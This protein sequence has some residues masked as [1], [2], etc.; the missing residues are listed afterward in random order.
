MFA[1]NQKTI[2][3]PITSS[4]ISG[5]GHQA[6][7]RAL[8]I[9]RVV[10]FTGSGVNYSFGQP[11]WG[12]LGLRATKL[13]F[14]LENS[15]L[16]SDHWKLP[17]E[18]PTP[19]QREFK[20]HVTNLVREIKRL[21]QKEKNNT[22]H[23][24]SLVETYF[25][26][27]EELIEIFR[28]PQVD[29]CSSFEKV[30]KSGDAFTGNVIVTFWDE[31][32]KA[33]PAQH[34]DSVMSM[35]GEGIAASD[36]I[37][38]PPVSKKEFR[39]VFAKRFSS[40]GSDGNLRWG[41]GTG[42]HLKENLDE[43]FSAAKFDPVKTKYNALLAPVLQQF[44]D[45]ENLDASRA[46]HTKLKINRFMTLNYDLELEQMLFEEAR[47]VPVPHREKFENFL[48]IDQADS[49]SEVE[50]GHAIELTSGSGRLIRSTSS[51]SDSLADLFSFGAFPTN[52]NTSVHHLHGRID[53]PANMIIIPQDYQRIYY[54][55]GDQPRSFDEA[56]HAVFTGS[57]ILFAGVGHSE[58]DVLKPL[59][60]FL[61][62]ETDRHDQHGNVYYLTAT[63]FN[64]ITIK[65]DH[66]FSDIIENAMA[67]NQDTT[68]DLFQTYGIYVLHTDFEWGDIEEWETD[69]AT[70]LT[71][72]IFVARHFESKDSKWSL[73]QVTNWASQKFSKDKAAFEDDSNAGVRELKL[74]AL[75]VEQGASG[76]ITG[77]AVEP[78]LEGLNSRLQSIG[79]VRYIDQVRKKQHEWWR[80]WSSRPGYRLAIYG[81]HGYQRDNDRN[82]ELKFCGLEQVASAKNPLVWRQTNL[83]TRIGNMPIHV[84]ND[85]EVPQFNSIFQ[86]THAAAYRAVQSSQ[87]EK[88]NL[89]F[90]ASIL[91]IGMPSGRSL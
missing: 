19:F 85:T 50:P 41:N 49:K 48:N 56:R 38:A 52:F 35:I 88:G 26:S 58:H 4:D 43:L 21:V 3:N 42:T 12:E 51:R 61:E 10:A 30:Y 16:E 29:F 1:Y 72:R 44:N 14:V 91:R 5:F 18:D 81:P 89:K 31:A 66:S 77:K 2:F 54:G 27:V 6:L 11:Q 7:L 70:L 28:I 87:D 84:E 57:D 20:R 15:I 53:D 32:R 79:L 13:F 45:L 59:R 37:K 25:E 47:S 76:A 36:E 8:N 71:A 82:R 68:Q 55:S 69:F 60:T 63:N 23:F 24:I 34:I 90:A 39:A 9:G 40:W 65:E 17:N 73:N 78:I 74:A 33:K 62:L 80:S 67:A 83:I 46:L 75:V 64:S 86:K 22:L